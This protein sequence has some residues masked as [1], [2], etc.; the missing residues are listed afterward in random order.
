MAGSVAKGS[1]VSPQLVLNPGAGAAAAGT[2]G[3][4]TAGAAPPSASVSP[5]PS[6][7]VTPEAPSKASDKPITAAEAAAL[8][9]MMRAVVTSGHAGFLASVP[10]APVGAKTG[11]AE[12]G[13]DNPPKTHAWIV[14]VHGDLAVAV[15]VEDGGLGATTSGPLLKQFLTA[16][17]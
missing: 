7:T 9:D 2:T 12:F 4:P 1:P 16:A 8:S 15:F 11:T 5:S 6:S 3:D 17:G 13:N 14:A 10:G